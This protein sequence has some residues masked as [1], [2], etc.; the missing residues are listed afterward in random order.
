MNETNTPLEQIIAIRR[1]KL[2]KLKQA[3]I[4]P[5]PTTFARTARVKEVIERFSGIQTGESS[6]DVVAVAGRMT[7]RR[8][9]GKACFIDITEQ[10]GRIQAYV[11]ADIVGPDSFKIFKDLVDL[12]DFIGVSGTPFRT[13]TGELS[14]KVERWT[15]LSKA[16]RP[17]PEKFTASRTRK[18]AT[19]RDTW[20][21]SP[22]PRSGRCSRSAAP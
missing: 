19:G 9:M 1:E 21:S 13:R 16:L 10:S 12:S 11:R 7:S 18:P 20:T 8:E 2:E 17:L 5:Y 3:G 4:N 22:I 6:T 14:I 15:L